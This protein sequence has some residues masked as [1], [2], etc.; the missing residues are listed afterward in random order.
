MQNLKLQPGGG[1]PLAQY[2]WIECV[3]A[4]GPTK[5]QPN[6]TTCG[7]T[8]K[9]GPFSDPSGGHTVCPACGQRYR[10]I[11]DTEAARA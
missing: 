8:V 11:D 9:F 1:L 5:F 3:A 10:R 2:G 6:R 7:N 4:A